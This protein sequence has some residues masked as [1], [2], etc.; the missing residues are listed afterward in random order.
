MH[1]T[2]NFIKWL[3]GPSRPRTSYDLYSLWR[4]STGK[5]EGQYVAEVQTNGRVVIVG[6]AQ[7]ALMLV[8][9][10]ATGAFKK[11]LESQRVKPVPKEV[12]AEIEEPKPDPF[13]IQAK[14]PSSRRFKQK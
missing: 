6:P 4:A 13:S 1:T 5:S 14:I 12:W 10:R 9:E 11:C 3:Q 2:I 8:S 7:E